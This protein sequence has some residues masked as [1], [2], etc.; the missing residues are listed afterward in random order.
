MK[1][2]LSISQDG[3]QAYN[4]LASEPT[5]YAKMHNLYGLMNTAEIELQ[6]MTCGRKDRTGR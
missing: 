6:H 5:T 1:F 4:R 3:K 2:F